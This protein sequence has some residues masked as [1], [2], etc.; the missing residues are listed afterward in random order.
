MSDDLETRVLDW[1]E[2]IAL[3]AVT[4]IQKGI[5][6]VNLEV[7]D[8]KRVTA[9]HV[10]ANNSEGV[11][12][13]N[14]YMAGPIRTDSEPDKWEMIDFNLKSHLRKSDNLRYLM[15]DQWQKSKGTQKEVMKL[16]SARRRFREGIMPLEFQQSINRKTIIAEYG[17]EGAF[18]A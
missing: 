4:G 18:Y 1:I 7:D 11:I 6:D 17:T 14:G 5:L 12:H 15:C 13:L 16:A 8:D 9:G 2:E 3:W 10:V